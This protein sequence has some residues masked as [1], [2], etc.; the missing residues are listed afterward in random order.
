MGEMLIA[1]QKWN[2]REKW[3]DQNSLKN[4]SYKRGEA[5]ASVQSYDYI[6]DHNGWIYL[7]KGWI[8]N[9]GHAIAKAFYSPISPKCIKCKNNMPDDIIPPI[10]SIMPYGGHLDYLVPKKEIDFVYSRSAVPLVEIEHSCDPIHGIAKSMEKANVECF[11]F[12]SRRLNIGSAYSDWDILCLSP[13]D[14]RLLIRLIIRGAGNGARLFTESECH[15]RAIRYANQPGSFEI[16]A[17]SILFN[18]TT[19]YLKTN[20]GEIGIFFGQTG[21]SSVVLDFDT[22][23]D[24]CCTEIIGAVLPVGGTSYDLPRRFS[25]QDS[26]GAVH[27]IMSTLWEIGGIEACSGRIVR[28][29]GLIPLGENSWWMGGLEAAVE[30][31]R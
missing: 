21:T 13:L 3:V 8:E 30:I 1:E 9:S 22:L 23:N 2:S 15:E 6:E 17:L 5:P 4:I 28:L 7:V 11:L 19:S 18:Y 16:D 20:C 29:S 14:P 25:I 26:D 10:H 31:L 27:F 12:G 24:L